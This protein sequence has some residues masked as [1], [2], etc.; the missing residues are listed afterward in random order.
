MDKKG[1]VFMYTFMLGT[2]IIVLGLAL[3]TPIKQVVDRAMGTAEMDCSSP[4]TDYIQATCWFLDI[5][6][7]LISGFIIL[8]GFGIMAAKR[9]II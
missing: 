6:K 5:E 1:L 7:P 9:Y 8:L 2:L 3:A 4:A